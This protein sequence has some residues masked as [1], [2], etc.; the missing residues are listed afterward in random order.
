[1][2]RLQ[3]IK[4]TKVLNQHFTIYGD[5]ENPLFLA[6]DVAKWIDHSQP[7]VM[8]K[9]I[10]DEEKVMNTIHTLGGNQEAWFLTED[11]VYEVLMQSRKPIAKQFKKQVKR[12][13]KDIRLY[14][15]YEVPATYADALLLAANLQRTVDVQEQLIGEYKPKV[16]YMDKI[17]KS[18]SLLNITQIAKDY[19]MSG[20]SINSLFSDL[21]IQFKQS[22][23]YLLRWVY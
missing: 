10:D 4:N 14:G 21:C 6:K 12:I 5:I 9:N 23:Q 2:S 18:K 15:R 19:W 22:D 16:D 1:M 17:L 11:G 8:L 13:L 20:Q 3:V 7:S